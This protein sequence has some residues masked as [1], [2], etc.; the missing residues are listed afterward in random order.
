[1]CR[2]P[3]ATC[4]GL[5]LTSCVSSEQAT[6]DQASRAR[7]AQLERETR[8]WSRD[9]LRRARDAMARRD[10]AR[11]RHAQVQG[12]RDALRQSSERHRPIAMQ[13]TLAASRAAPPFARTKRGAPLRPMTGSGDRGR[14]AD[15]PVG[16][17]EGDDPPRALHPPTCTI[18][19]NAAPARGSGS[20]R[21]AGTAHPAPSA[22]C[23]M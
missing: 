11:G 14:W 17:E 13:R 4:G 18:L 6:R 5:Y 19:E 2:A 23:A 20:H 7:S 8:G 21:T 16:E 10:G 22:T 3:L 12:T 1:M 15:H 9:S